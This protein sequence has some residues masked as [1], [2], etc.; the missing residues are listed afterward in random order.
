VTFLVGDI[1]EWEPS[2]TF[3]LVLSTYALPGGESSR[4]ALATALAAL[5]PGGTLTVV[6]WDLSMVRRLGVR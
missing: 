3:D 1:T 2:G 5:A 6:E 4:R